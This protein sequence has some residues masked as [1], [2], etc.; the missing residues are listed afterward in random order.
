LQAA[1]ADCDEALRLEP[2][3]LDARDSR[4]FTYMKLGEIDSAIKE[5]DT[6]LR[7]DPEKPYSLYGRGMAKRK[8]GDV[9]G[10]EADILAA[11]AIKADIAEEFAK[12]GVRLGDP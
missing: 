9:T 6:V 12:I 11:K 2:Y 7:S 3:Y 10:G 4:A 5:Y 1:L 8:K